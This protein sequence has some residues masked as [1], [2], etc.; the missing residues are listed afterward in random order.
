MFIVVSLSIVILIKYKM[1]ISYVSVYWKWWQ[2]AS[3][4][5][6]SNKQFNQIIDMN[7]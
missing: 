2:Q 4:H 7:I 5:I 3:D 1:A 6:L